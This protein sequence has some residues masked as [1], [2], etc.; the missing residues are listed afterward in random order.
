MTRPP[1]AA[2]CQAVSNGD[3]TLALFLV[4]AFYWTLQ[5]IRQGH[6]TTSEGINADPVDVCR[7]R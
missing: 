5:S 4:I 2:F 1:D 6:A 7:Q 3:G